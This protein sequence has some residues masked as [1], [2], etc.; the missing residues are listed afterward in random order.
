M[1]RTLHN[2]IYALIGLALLA[3]SGCSSDDSTATESPNTGD[4]KYTMVCKVK[5]SNFASVIKPE[6]RSQLDPKYT[7]DKAACAKKEAAK[8]KRYK[9]R[10]NALLRYEK[11]TLNT[12]IT[13]ASSNVDKTLAVLNR[14]CHHYYISADNAEY[15]TD[16]SSVGANYLSLYRSAYSKWWYPDENL[17]LPRDLASAILAACP[18]QVIGGSAG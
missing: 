11:R 5:T 16:F 17:T 8:N 18:R 6:Q 10:T 2:T 9:A 12:V 7:Y 3:A 13:R 1:S 15:K 14:A 4:A